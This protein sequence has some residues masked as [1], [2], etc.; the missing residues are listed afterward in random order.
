[1][2][3]RIIVAVLSLS[4]LCCH[5][6]PR[7]LEL[8]ASVADT[9]FGRAEASFCDAAPKLVETTRPFFPFVALAQV[10][11][12]GAGGEL[13]ALLEEAERRETEFERR[14]EPQRIVL[15]GAADRRAL[16]SNGETRKVAGCYAELSPLI[17][18]PYRRG[19]SGAFL[20][21]FR[22][23]AVG[24]SGSTVFW[25]AVNSDGSVARLVRLPLFVD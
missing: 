17:E 21:I 9:I 14:Y 22:G 18:N 4:V 2:A 3:P 1:M 23:G 6:L 7:Q 11:S 8:Q 25:L 15:R 5:T 13:L 12:D 10:E 24:R 16:I 19:E 20:R